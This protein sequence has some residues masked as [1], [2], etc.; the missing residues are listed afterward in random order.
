LAASSVHALSVAG[1]SVIV[2]LVP[3]WTNLPPNELHP[4]DPLNVLPSD[5]KSSA[6]TAT[7][8]TVAAAST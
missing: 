5:P 2:S 6:A 7:A 3:S 8:V 4:V 1:P